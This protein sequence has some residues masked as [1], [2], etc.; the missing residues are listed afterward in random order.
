MATS[1]V[2]VSVLGTMPGGEVWSVNPNFFLLDEPADVSAAEALAIATAVDAIAMPSNLRITM[3]AQTFFTG[4]RVEARD[5]NG[6]LQ[7][8]GEHTKSTPVAGLGTTPHPYQTSTVTSLRSAFPGAQGRGRLY[9][10]ATGVALVGTTLRMDSSL[11]GLF[12]TA[13]KSYLAS[14]QAAVAASAGPA[15]LT[16]WSRTGSAFHAVTTMRQ[17]DVLDT[18]RR[19]RDALSESYSELSYP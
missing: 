14:I 8:L 17:G 16:V 19:R 12:L 11:C 13:V 7:A 9:W 4:T 1:V 15:S 5:R 3:N 10:P 18:Q 2:K 6:L